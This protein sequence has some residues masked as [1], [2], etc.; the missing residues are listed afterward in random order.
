MAEQN[1]LTDE[2]IKDKEIKLVEK[3]KKR[4]NRAENFRKP[5]QQAW[6]RFYKLYRA[7]KDKTSYAYKTR[8]MPPIAFEIVETVKPRLSSAKMNVRILPRGKND[9]DSPAIESWDDLIK[10]D[11]DAIK[12]DDRKIDWINSSL[13]YGN[14]VAGLT[15]NPG[16]EED[17]DPYLEIQDL[18]LFYPD[19][20]A[21]SFQDSKWE[22]VQLFKT[23]EQLKKEEEKRGENKIY[24]NLEGLEN[25]KITNDPR[26]ERY[27][28]NTKKMGQIDIGGTT[29]EGEP[30]SGTSTD[31]KMEEEQVELWQIWDH[32][33]DKL[34][35]IANREKLLREDENPYLKINGGRIFIDLPDHA[36]LWELW[37]IGHI[38]PVETTIHEVADSRNQAMDN[39]TFN[40]D[41]IKKVRKDAHLTADDLITGPG[42]I[43]ELKRADDVITERPPDI[44]KE[45]IEKDEVLRREIQTALAISEYAMGLPKGPQEPMGKV[46]LLL[47]QTNIRFSL[48]LRQLEIAMTQLVNNLIELNDEFLTEDKAYRLIGDEVSFKDFKQ[49][50]KKIKVDA[51]VE[52]EAKVE[53]TPEQRKVEAIELYKIFVAEDKPDPEDV[54]AIKQWKIRKRALQKVILEQFDMEQYEDLILGPKEKVEKKAPELPPE[55][56]PAIPAAPTPGVIPPEMPA[57]IKGL[58]AKIPLLNRIVK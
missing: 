43:W 22:I 46:E 50:D 48:L 3:W 32:E 25:K 8:L 44:S 21:T 19:P 40:L 1:Q 2:E 37:A 55:L 10:Y 4:F 9:I 41:P 36:L 13:I 34:I 12:F 35:V 42:A 26:K 47:M 16:E 5:K 58:I 38:E 45:W 57:G 27:E 15:W 33:E 18:W 24:K 17:G 51:I 23:N 11:L 52:I 39:I 49:D 54:E 28:I 20:E 7:Y 53:K 56:P 29:K 6:L 31:E 14:G 30:L